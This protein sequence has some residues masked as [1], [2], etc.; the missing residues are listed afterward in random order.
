[1]PSPSAYIQEMRCTG[2]AWNAW[3]ACK[4]MVTELVKPTYTATKPAVKAYRLRTLE[5]AW[6]EILAWARA[7][8][9]AALS[10]C[11]R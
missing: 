1:M 8:P 10:L 11:N 2:V 9:H 6:G 7:P 4:T 5:I 3:A